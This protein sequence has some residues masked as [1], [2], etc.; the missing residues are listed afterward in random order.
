MTNSTTNREPI[1]IAD[2]LSMTYH[3]GPTAVTAL[4]HA[5]LTVQPGEFVALVGRSGSGKS[6]LLSLL[7][8]LEKPTTGTVTVAGTSLQKLKA[9][10]A[11]IF[12]RE[13][14][15]FLFQ[16]VDLLPTLTVLEN[17]MLPAALNGMAEAQ[18]RAAATELLDAVGIGALAESLPDQLSGGQRQR[19]GLARAL[20]NRPQ[21]ILA[22]EPTG[23]LDHATG[24]TV[25]ALLKQLAHQEHSALILA[26][27]DPEVARQ[28]D[29][30]VAVESGSVVS[31]Q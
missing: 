8:G 20:I 3:R 25:V 19:A 6:T 24:Q 9:K 12:R 4:T 30:V 18:C 27:H 31:K 23:S 28:A 2:D 29:R 17:V 16:A 15:G 13:H 11:A 22:D 5:H 14:I 21:L 7:G 10:P 26:T 1:V